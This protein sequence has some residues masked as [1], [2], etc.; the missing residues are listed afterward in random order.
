M[1]SKVKVLQIIV[2]IIAGLFLILGIINACQK[3][4]AETKYS[5]VLTYARSEFTCKLGNN[6]EYRYYKNDKVEV[7]STGKYVIEGDTITFCDVST[8]DSNFTRNIKFTISGSELQGS[9]TYHSQTSWLT[10]FL[11]ISG[12]VLLFFDYVF[13]RI[14]RHQSISSEE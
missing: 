11:I 9:G 6:Y 13:Y 7:I 8:S 12:V 14:A 1:K 10:L 5:T 3:V 2:A 4:P